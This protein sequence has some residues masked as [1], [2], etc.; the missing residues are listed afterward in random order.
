[1]DYSMVLATIQKEFK[2]LIKLL[3]F[4]SPYLYEQGFL[5]FTFLKMKNYS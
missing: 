4:P 5:V 1:M 3:P 2:E